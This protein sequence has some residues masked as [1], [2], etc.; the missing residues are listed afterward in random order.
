ME[1]RK[2]TKRHSWL[3]YHLKYY[4]YELEYNT[5]TSL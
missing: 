4:K 3:I 1:K 5:Y 2:Y